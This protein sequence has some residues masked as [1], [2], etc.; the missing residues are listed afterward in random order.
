MIQRMPMSGIRRR[1]LTIL[2]A[3]F[4]L[5][6]CQQ[7]PRQL[8]FPTTAESIRAGLTVPDYVDV[9]DATVTPPAGWQPDPLKS[10]D[11]HTH[12]VWLSP[13]G[14]TAYG[15]IYFIMPFPAGH[16]V[17]LWGFLRQMRRTEG[18]SQLV[19][20]Q[21]DPNSQLLRFVAQGGKYVVRSNLSVHGSRGWA[22]Y[23]GTRKNEPIE[24]DELELAEQAREHTRLG[25]AVA[26]QDARPMGNEPGSG[27]L[28]QAK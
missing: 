3:A 23:A 21:W 5:A 10:S 6:G 22:V 1:L 18:E 8:A 14:R 7:H 17:A 27:D 28:S 16:D 4:A 9:I 2:L 12:Q 25:R 13:S 20:K 19:S 15:V 26:G 11:A 24:P